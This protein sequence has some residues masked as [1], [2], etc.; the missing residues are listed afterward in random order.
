MPII[1]SPSSAQLIN[2]TSTMDLSLQPIPK[3]SSKLE[4][5][6]CEET[7]AEDYLQIKYKKQVSTIT[8]N[9]TFRREKL[10]DREIMEQLLLQRNFQRDYNK[11]LDKYKTEFKAKI[12][13]KR[14]DNFNKQ[15][16]LEI[17]G[18]A[19]ELAELSD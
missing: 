9:L 17:E 10:E 5:A 19:L 15:K 13:K 7:M 16:K 3:I 8:R 11:R 2:S 4:K 6:F 18:K 1:Q 12:Q 14:L